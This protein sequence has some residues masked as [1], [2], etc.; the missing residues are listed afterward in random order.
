MKGSPQRPSCGSEAAV[1][2]L[3]DAVPAAAAGV[4]IRALADR[5]V[6]LGRPAGCDGVLYGLQNRCAA[7]LLR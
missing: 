1:A 2:K 3:A 5:P 6:R 4:A 7:V